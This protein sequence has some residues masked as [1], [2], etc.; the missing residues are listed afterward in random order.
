M[1]TLIEY[2]SFTFE[3]KASGMIKA[4]TTGVT[5]EMVQAYKKA[6][7]GILKR[8]TH[9]SEAILLATPVDPNDF[10]HSAYAPK[11]ANAMQCHNSVSDLKAR[12]VKLIGND[13]VAPPLQWQ[14]V[15][16][17]I[18]AVPGKTC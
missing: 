2:L 3:I 1:Q 11:V 5:K 17:C 8:M 13:F 18:V 14:V 9:I 6:E 16:K 10:D 12:G 7:D 4:K 15:Q